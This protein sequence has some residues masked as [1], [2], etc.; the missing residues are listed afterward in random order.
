MASIDKLTIGQKGGLGAKS[1]KNVQE[2][3]WKMGTTESI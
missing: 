1:F 3:G 2:F